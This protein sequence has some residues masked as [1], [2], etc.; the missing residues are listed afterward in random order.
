MKS[1]HASPLFC[2]LLL[3]AVSH[4][5]Y[6]LDRIICQ[7]IH[8]ADPN[9]QS[10]VQSKPFVEV[11]E[12]EVLMPPESVGKWENGSGGKTIFIH[13]ERKKETDGSTSQDLSKNIHAVMSG[14]QVGLPY[15]PR[16]CAAGN[17]DPSC[18]NILSLCKVHRKVDG[19]KQATCRSCFSERAGCVNRLFANVF[20]EAG[21]CTNYVCSRQT[22]KHDFL[23]LINGLFY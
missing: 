4:S 20:I 15:E 6:F 16:R 3:F 21:S 10:Q 18:T 12:S 7:S 1:L 9:T 14:R 8:L 22:D 17:N 19:K 23:E 2:L 5:C 13:N 11:P